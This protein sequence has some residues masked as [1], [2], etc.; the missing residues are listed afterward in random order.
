V[1]S[2]PYGVF[3]GSGEKP[4]LG[5]VARF[6]HFKML[7][8]FLYEVAD[9]D[10]KNEALIG[11]V[12]HNRVEAV[13]ILIRAGAD[14]NARGKLFGKPVFMYVTK[15]TSREIIRSL[16]EAGVMDLSAGDDPQ[17]KAVPN[18]TPTTN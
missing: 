16:M 7:E 6:G 10:E 3:L 5:D 8:E 18:H 15:R 9:Q 2:G 14:V 13:R 17:V 1:G 11:A 12:I 4:T